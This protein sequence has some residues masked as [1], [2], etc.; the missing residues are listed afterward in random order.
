M[1]ID[2]KS[3]SQVL[4]PA[5]MQPIA[6]G[7]RSLRFVN[8]TGWSRTENPASLDG[9]WDAAEPH[10]CPRIVCLLSKAVPEAE[11]AKHLAGEV[12]SSHGR[13]D[14]EKNPR[15][16]MSYWEDLANAATEGPWQQDGPWWHDRR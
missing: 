15:D 5:L 10:Q 7:P 3:L 2:P 6:G 4:R 14:E 11:G 16:W 13:D 1:S 8:A 12:S 9:H